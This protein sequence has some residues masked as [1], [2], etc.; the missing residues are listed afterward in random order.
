MNDGQDL[1]QLGFP[2]MLEHLQGHRSPFPL[3]SGR[4]LQARNACRNTVQTRHIEL[5]EPRLLKL[6]LYTGLS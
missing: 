1:D 5:P 6:T 3:G 4:A 2:A